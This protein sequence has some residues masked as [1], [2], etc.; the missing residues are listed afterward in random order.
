[1]K[2]TIFIFNDGTGQHLDS[3]APTNVAKLFWSLPGQQT[4]N[5]LADEFKIDKTTGN[6][7]IYIR[8]IGTSD[9]RYLQDR[10]AQ[11]WWQSI[12]RSIKKTVLGYIEQIEGTTIVDRVNRSYDIFKSIYIEGD[13]VVLVGFS[14]GAASI[15]IL[16]SEL[17]KDYKVTIKYMLIF[18][19]V[20]SVIGKIQILDNEPTDRF[21][22]LDIHPNI[23]R[24]DHLIAGDEMREKFPF[25]SVNKRDGVR[26]ILFTGSHS[27]VGGGHKITGLSDIALQFSLDQF[28][29]LNLPCNSEEIARLKLTPDPMAA[30]TFVILSGTGQRHFPRKL[31]DIDFTVHR[32]VIERSQAKGS[33]SIALGNLCNF[34]TKNFKDE[35]ITPKDILA[36]F[37][38][39]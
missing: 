18:D 4:E 16:A 17:I 27:D 30:I 35:L 6:V 1:M 9:S 7:A 14:R 5:A 24:C 13:D 28:R 31:K 32:S 29:D 21:T 36:G 8:G 2:K 3:D 39:F 12:C 33:A 25:S 37:D 22:N 15:R 23:L 34:S 19:T 20:Y 10:P 11:N 38:F 26:Q